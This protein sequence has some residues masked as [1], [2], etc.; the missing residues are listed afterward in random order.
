MDYRPRNRRGGMLGEYKKK[1]YV[2][3]KEA[4]ADLSRVVFLKKSYDVL[5]CWRF[6]RKYPKLDGRAIHIEL[7]RGEGD[8]VRHL[9]RNGNCTNI[10]HLIR[11]SDI[12][13][14]Y[15]ELE[16]DKFIVSYLRDK[17]GE[18]YEKEGLLVEKYILCARATRLIDEYKFNYAIWE[19]TNK[20]VDEYA[21]AEEKRIFEN[22]KNSESYQ[23]YLNFAKEKFDKMVVDFKL[24][25]YRT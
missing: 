1:P 3:Y 21:A 4:I 8:V 25:V 22:L 12:E 10:L 14:A 5:G 18:N 13:N 6:N 24:T 19:V 15:D 20:I 11:G 23:E 7:A 17:L 9:C 16:V 2:D